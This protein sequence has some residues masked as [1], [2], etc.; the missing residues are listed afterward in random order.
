MRMIFDP[1]RRKENRAARLSMALF[2]LSQ[3]IKKMTQTE[4]DVR[5]L[6][7]VQIHALLFAYYTREDVAS[8]G[9]LASAIGAT[10]VTAVKIV[11]GLVK[12]GLMAKVQKSEDRRVSL[13]Q[14]T[15]KGKEV[16][17]TLDTWG[18]T[19]ENALASIPEDVL[20]DFEL[21]L[22]AVLSTMRKRGYLVVAEPCWGC[23]YFRPHTGRG[24]TPHYCAYIEKYLSHD[25]SLKECPEHTP[26]NVPYAH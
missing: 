14:L 10:H 12:K 7:P 26:S 15:A 13:L 20:S 23:L 17:L 2:R 24:T 6:S 5:G 11:N 19:L 18:E 3:A 21:G 25:A 22:G 1:Q 9:H 8:V 16:A 4:S